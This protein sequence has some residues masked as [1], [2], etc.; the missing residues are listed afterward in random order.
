[1]KSQSHAL[2]KEQIDKVVSLYS[3][4]RIEESINAIKALNN[5]YPNVPLLFNLLGAC[6]KALGKLQASA[7][8]FEAATTIKPDYAEAYN[9]LGIVQ[10]QL[11]SLDVSVESFKRAIAIKPDYV[12]AHGN[13][14][15][16]LKELNRIEEAVK[17][18]GMHSDCSAVVCFAEPYFPRYWY[19]LAHHKECWFDNGEIALS[20][21]RRE[22]VVAP[23]MQGLDSVYGPDR[24]I[25]D[26]SGRL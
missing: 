21:E 8:A 17:A 9:N 15:V 13:L 26:V 5:D 22:P 11:R 23:M 2:S 3:S 16:V 7:K 4:G 14:G 18:Y 12:E 20:V 24:P 25:F 6:Y 19:K 1:M 10:M